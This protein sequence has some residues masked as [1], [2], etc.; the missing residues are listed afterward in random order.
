MAFIRLSRACVGS[1][2][3]LLYVL[4]S[5]SSVLIFPSYSVWSITTVAFPLSAG[6]ITMLSSCFRS[7]IAF[8]FTGVRLVV[9]GL[10]FC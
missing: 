7:L 10:D 3:S 5:A 4:A 1:L 2:G 8:C 9:G 6:A